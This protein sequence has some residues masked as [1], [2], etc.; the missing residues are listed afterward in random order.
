MR[1]YF[2][3][4]WDDSLRSSA[5]ITVGLVLVLVSV[6]ICTRFARTTVTLLAER[7]TLLREA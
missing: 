7:I 3:G 5:T 2:L 6:L 1:Y 4:S